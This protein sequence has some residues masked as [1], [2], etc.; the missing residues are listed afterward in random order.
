MISNIAA[1][2]LENLSIVRYC[3][4]DLESYCV[5]G[6]AS[7]CHDSFFIISPDIE[8]E[9]PIRSGL[10]CFGFLCYNDSEIEAL[11]T[12]ESRNKSKPQ[13]EAAAY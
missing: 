5:A 3:D 10:P 2:N 7:F 6:P 4:L 8:S 9:A 13:G 12:C 11:D 1:K